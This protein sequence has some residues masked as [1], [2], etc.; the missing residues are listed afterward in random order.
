MK[1]QEYYKIEN[2]VYLLIFSLLFVNKKKPRP[3][4]VTGLSFIQKIEVKNL[5]LSQYPPH[6]VAKDTSSINILTSNSSI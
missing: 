4:Q 5:I 6:F 2:R 1:F 3:L